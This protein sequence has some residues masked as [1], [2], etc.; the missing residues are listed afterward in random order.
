MPGWSKRKRDIVEAAFYQ[1]LN[2]YSIDSKDDGHICLGEN[3]YDG[4]IR[5]ITEIFDAL[6]R[7]GC[8]MKITKT[9]AKYQD[10]PKALHKCEGCS[11]FRKP[12]LCTLV[13]GRI[14][15]HGWCRHWER[16][17]K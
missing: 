12:D 4:Q 7:D 1:F 17:D 11:M 6:E 14:S 10:N 13:E 15:S 9:E 2:A 8:K 5:L 3:L 16:K